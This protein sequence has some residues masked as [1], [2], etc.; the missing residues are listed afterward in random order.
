MSNLKRVYQAGVY[1][2]DDQTRDLIQSADFVV[3]NLSYGPIPLGA[4]I[5]DEEGR[6]YTVIAK[7]SDKR[8]LLCEPV[9]KPN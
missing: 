8:I 6:S 1:P 4:V 2:V 7:E 9:S 3:L 5:F